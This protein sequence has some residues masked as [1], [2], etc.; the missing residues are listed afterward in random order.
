MEGGSKNVVLEGPKE[1]KMEESTENDDGSKEDKPHNK[2]PMD[3]SKTE[4][5]NFEENDD[6]HLHLSSD[7]D[8]ELKDLK[9]EHKNVSCPKCPKLFKTEKNLENHIAMI[10][11]GK[12][13]SF[14]PIRNSERRRRK[15]RNQ[16]VDNLDKPFHYK[17]KQCPY[18]QK[19]FSRNGTLRHHIK[20]V[21]TI[22][23]Y[24]C[25]LIQY[26]I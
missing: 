20:T 2:V 10:H 23:F 7:S 11:D 21:S 25:P 9:E 16:D 3:I 17:V 15:V 6:M 18:C 14:I 19:W 4:E 26:E 5:N 24:F 13:K 1:L 12:S 8:E 22:S